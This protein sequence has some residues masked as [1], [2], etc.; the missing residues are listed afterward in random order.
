MS[1]ID[2]YKKSGVVSDRPWFSTLTCGE[3]SFF[4]GEECDGV[5]NEGSEKYDES[6]A[7]EEFEEK[8]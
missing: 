7:C 6:Q 4:T 5:A 2:E 1:L 8:A 3:C